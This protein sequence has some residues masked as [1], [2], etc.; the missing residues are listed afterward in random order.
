M[1]I[2]L[3][4]S[5]LFRNKKRSSLTLLGV[6]IGVM[7]IISLVS[8]SEGMAIQSSDL[9]EGFQGIFV[10]EKGAIDVPFSKLDINE[11]TKLE[12]IQGVGTVV[13]ELWVQPKNLD[14]TGELQRL[15][16]MIFVV[17]IAPELTKGYYIAPYYGVSKGREIKYTDKNS[18]VIGSLLAE[19]LNLQVGQNIKVGDTK[20]NIVGIFS[21]DMRMLNLMIITTL[22]VA[23]DLGEI[24]DKDQ[25]NLFQV[26]PST[27]EGAVE[28]KKRLTQRFEDNYNIMSMQEG[29]EMLDKF[30]GGLSIVLWAISGIAGVVGGIGVTNTMLMSVMERT[31]EFGVLKA[32]GWKNKDLIKMIFYESIILSLVGAIIGILLSYLGVQYFTSLFGFPLAVTSNLILQAMFFA[33]TLGVIGGIF[34]AYKTTKMSPIEAV[35]G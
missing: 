9:L 10:Y 13:P 1:M 14:F 26:I 12:K 19:E 6:I 33:L 28:L 30:I 18:I 5:N 21:S 11:I 2:K 24:E 16:N 31:K 17:G 8:I 3:V 7:T 27:P 29:G 15:A 25:I 35:R 34:P 4:I 32:I 20:Y 23:R 22:D